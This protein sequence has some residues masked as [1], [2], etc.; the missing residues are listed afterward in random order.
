MD[1]QRAIDA[2]RWLRDRRWFRIGVNVALVL[3]LVLFVGCHLV[4]DWQQITRAEIKP[5]IGYLWV[6]LAFL[7]L[8]GVNLVILSVAWHA[9]IR[10]FGGPTDWRQNFLY[11]SY[12]NIAAFL[13]TPVWFLA[14]RVHFYNQAGMRWSTTLT[15]TALETALHIVTGLAVYAAL[16]I[17]PAR[18]ETWPWALALALVIA[19]LIRPRWLALPWLNKGAGPDISRRDAV[20]WL[21]LYALT[22]LM[23][24][25]FF[26]IVIGI[27]GPAV[28]PGLGDL[29]RIW[30][31]AGVVSY[32]AAY[33]LGGIGILREFTL[34]WFLS[35][36]YSPTEALL[37][38]AGVRLLLTLGGILWGLA[39]IA[40]IRTMS[41][42]HPGKANR[43]AEKS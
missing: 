1:G 37:I 13:P 32:V 10:R 22:W 35:A 12:T 31:L 43:E 16:A 2:L 9:I 4:T 34:T 38:A 21:T 14:S 3:I 5:D 36:F 39:I 17:H 18:P 15:T 40:L 27:L 20:I 30:I 33:T 25:V 6:A 8:Y 23:A 24:G 29:W 26:T 41:W 11:Y 7:G 19:A 42:R 28:L